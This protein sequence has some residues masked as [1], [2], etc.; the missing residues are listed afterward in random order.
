VHAGAMQH[1]ERASLFV[2]LLSPPLPIVCRG[3]DGEERITSSHDL[4]SSMFGR[5][6]CVPAEKFVGAYEEAGFAGDWKSHVL[7]G[8]HAIDLLESLACVTGD[9]MQMTEGVAVEHMY[10]DFCTYLREIIN[11][12]GGY[13]MFVMGN[14]RASS[15]DV[16]FLADVRRVNAAHHT[17]LV[18][19]AVDFYCSLL[20]FR[21]E[22]TDK[23]VKAARK[24]MSRAADYH[25]TLYKCM[26]LIRGIADATLDAEKS[27][28]K[29]VSVA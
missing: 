27:T 15:L 5:L 20:I 29:L 7:R 14:K 25:Y 16:R 1:A 21:G 8:K 22:M 24:R 13:D 12:V 28:P 19:S 11:L 23:V 2:Q 18:F 10:G 4:L 26:D 3:S 6:L 9:S 17:A